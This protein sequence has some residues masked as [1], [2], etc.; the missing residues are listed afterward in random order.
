MLL[1]TAMATIAL[2]PTFSLYISRD[3]SLII[4][5]T[6]VINSFRTAPA[7][8]LLRSFSY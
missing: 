6:T 1:L 2:F 8:D 3:F 7:S 5:S 4:Q